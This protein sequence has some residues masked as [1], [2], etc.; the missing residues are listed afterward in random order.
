[1]TADPI[2][3]SIQEGKESSSYPA[4]V[5]SLVAGLQLHV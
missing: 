4:F 5:F 2:I 1:M 3:N